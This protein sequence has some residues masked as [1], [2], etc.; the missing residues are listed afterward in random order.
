MAKAANQRMREIEKHGYVLSTDEGV[1]GTNAYNRAKYY[2][3]SELSLKNFSEGKK[4][5]IEQIEDQIYQ[6]LAFMNA[7]GST[8]SGIK[9]HEKNVEFGIEKTTA[10][11]FEGDYTSDRSKNLLKSFFQSAAWNELRERGGSAEMVREASA[12]FDRGASLKTLKAVFKD[13][14][15][16]QLSRFQVWQGWSSGMK[17]SD[18]RRKAGIKRK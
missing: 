18:I 10:A 9:E 1:S 17:A 15:K 4:R 11:L 16:G 6:Q 5:S 7:Q 3:Q 13:Y 12:A 14:Q 2:L 8:I